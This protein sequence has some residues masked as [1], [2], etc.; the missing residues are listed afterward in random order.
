MQ[1]GT[2]GTKKK[3]T[4]E[5]FFMLSVLLVNGGNYIYNLLLGRL[6]GPA[7]FADAAVLITFLL[8][9]S[10][11]AM[12]YQLV[13]AK[14]AVL[15]EEV[16]LPTFLR[17]VLK[18][19]LLVGVVAGIAVMLFS[20]QLQSIFHTTSS[21][22][23]IIFGAA[24]PFY[25]LLS[26][27]RGYLQGKSDFKGLAITYQSEMLVRLGL[28]L[29]LLFVLDI[30]PITIVAIG[31]FV[32][33]ILGLFPFKMSSLLHLNSDRIEPV[34]SQQ[35]QRFFLVTLFYELT[36]IIINNSDIL[37]VK[38]YFID[39]QAGLYASLALI[40][41]VVY[42]MAWM[43]VMLLLPKVITLQK[44]GKETHQ[45]LFKY[46]G[47]ITLLCAVIITGTALFPELVVQLLFG[48]AYVE[49]AP[50]L[51]KY[52]VA[53]SLFAIANIFSY[54][55][56]SLGKYKPVIISGI[57]GMAQVVLIVF[58]HDSLEQVVIVQIAAMT[59]LMVMQVLYFIL[60]KRNV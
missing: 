16:Q 46:V 52:A 1:L 9:L 45:L 58:Y 3:I 6:L 60:S 8:V 55:F 26:V 54:Y 25:F 10:F 5:Q 36:Q 35:I 17:R 50:L 40:G 15:L 43:F 34:M 33:L 57:M 20:S 11:L 2:L 51:W 19:S 31:I 24:V 42:F 13:T 32:S 23:F 59:A 38:H 21:R 28:T 14:Y 18:S 7:Q 27:N 12:T 39:T 37:L 22:M 41:R 49:I 47:Y 29:L 53:T 30:D 56:L 48:N 44:E 4:P